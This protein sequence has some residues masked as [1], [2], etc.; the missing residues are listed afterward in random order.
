MMAN[1]GRAG[2]GKTVPQAFERLYFLERRAQAQCWLSTRRRCSS[3]R[4]VIKKTVAQ[5]GAGGTVGG[6]DRVD[7]HSMC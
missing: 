5:F 4:A 2:V 3:F 1:H 7:L 6:R